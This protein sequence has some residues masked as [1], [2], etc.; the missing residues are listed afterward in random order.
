MPL[1]SNY[2]VRIGT[3]DQDIATQMY[4]NSNLDLLGMEMGSMQ[5]TSNSCPRSCALD[6]LVC[7]TRLNSNLDPLG[8]EMGSVQGTSK[9]CPRSC[10]LDLDE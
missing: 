6:S 5:S 7:V 3:Q 4:A 10:A 2:A 9:T 8:T 1:V